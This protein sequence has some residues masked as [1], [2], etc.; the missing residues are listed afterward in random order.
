MG[1]RVWSALRR[2]VARVADRI[3]QD[4]ELEPK[5]RREFLAEL[6]MNDGKRK[7][8]ARG[9]L[10]FRGAAGVSKRE[11]GWRLLTSDCLIAAKD[12]AASRSM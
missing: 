9:L 5:A 11:G 8:I 12:Q 3:W 4:D 7:A 6:Y 2:V 10:E 1:L